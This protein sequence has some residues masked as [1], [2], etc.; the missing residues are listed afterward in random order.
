MWNEN[1]G[2]PLY[3]FQAYGKTP[4]MLSM[5][6]G[7]VGDTAVWRAQSDY[8]KTWRFKHPSPW[9]Y[10][11]FMSN[12]AEEG[13]G[14]VLVLLAILYRC[15]ERID[16]ERDDRRQAAR[17]SPFVRMAQMPSPVVLKVQFASKGA[18]IRKMPNARMTDSVTAIVT[19]P[20]DVWFGGSRTFK[21]TLDFGG[22]KIAQITLDPNGRFPNRDTT[23]SVWPRSKPS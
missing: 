16:R 14:L 15:G 17:P 4:L 3:G 5:L 23:N 21:A 13:S 9:D 8:A 20:V 11:F 12:G 10:A 18:P 19:Y 7:V 22:R 2:G 6:G 1:Y